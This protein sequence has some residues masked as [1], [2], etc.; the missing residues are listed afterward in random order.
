MLTDESEQIPVAEITRIEI[1]N[2]AIDAL[3]RE[4]LPIFDEVKQ[5]DRKEFD[6]AVLKSLGFDK[7]DEVLQEL[8][9][10]LIEVVEDRL[11]KANLIKNREP[12]GS[13]RGLENK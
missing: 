3:K 9:A 6:L 2:R 4:P 1:D 13:R 8:S 11:I 12:E 5:D 10:A 7:A